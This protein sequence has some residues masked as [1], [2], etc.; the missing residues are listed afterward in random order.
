M[1]LRS[2]G[3]DTR[4]G[5]IGGGA[6]GLTAAHHLAQAGFSH[7]TVL[8][9]EARVGGKCCSV[10]VGSHVYELG[11]VLGNRDYT[12][13]LDLMRAVGVQGGP[14]EGLHCYDMNGRPCDLFPRTEIPRVAWQVLVHYAWATQVRYRRI[15]EPGLAG[16]HRNLSEPFSEFARRHS[17]ESLPRAFS[18]PFT[19]FGYGF[20]DEVPAAYVLKYL[21]LHMVES[22]VAPS[23]RIEWPDGTEALWTRLAE[24]HDVRTATTVRRV[25]RGDTVHVETDNGPLEFDALILT[26]PLDQALGFLDATPTERRLFSAIR[27]YDYH[28]L[29]CRISGLPEGSGLLP[30]HFLARHYGHVLLWYHRNHDDPLYTVYAL[31]D[32]HQ[33]ED[34]IERTCAADLRQL[35]ARLEQVVHARRWHYF[36]HVTSEVM[37]GGFYDD[38]ERLQGTNS[39]YYAGEIMSFATVELCARYSRDLVRRFFEADPVPA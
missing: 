12:A 5:I 33:T 32:G 23:R 13:T 24:R 30:A 31:G 20:F 17:L 16:V 15:Q 38:L 8:E 25:T 1:S 37:A 4:I 10:P 28:V 34:E 39:T 9:R 21:D 14:T 2:F 22:L 3:R 7:V 26:S 35:G 6:S 18:P 19:A 29:L 36:P 11:A 27:T